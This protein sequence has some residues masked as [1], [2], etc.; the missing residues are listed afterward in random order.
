MAKKQN[1]GHKKLG[2]A[3]SNKINYTLLVIYPMSYGKLFLTK[4]DYHLHKIV[5]LLPLSQ[6]EHFSPADVSQWLRSTHEPGGLLGE[7][8]L[9]GHQQCE[10]HSLYSAG[11]NINKGLSC[12]WFVSYPTDFHVAQAILLTHHFV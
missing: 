2:Y 11:L 12:S 9:G 10:L 8:E 5:A 7:R 6:R 3:H 1:S 4:R